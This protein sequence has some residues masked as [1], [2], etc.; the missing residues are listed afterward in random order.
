MYAYISEWVRGILNA[1]FAAV[2]LWMY[3]G[4]F[5]GE[6][7]EDRKRLLFWIPFL[8]WHFLWIWLVL[9]GVRLSFPVNTLINTTCVLTAA[10]GAY[11]G[12]L[13]IKAGF[14]IAYVGID[15]LSE[16]FVWFCLSVFYAPE[17]LEQLWWA[18][19]L[20]RGVMIGFILILR[21]FFKRKYRTVDER[22]NAYLLFVSLGSIFVVHIIFQA[23]ERQEVGI[24]LIYAISCGLVMMGVNALVYLI[25]Y[26][27]C[28]MIE[29]RQ[30]KEAFEYLVKQYSRRQKEQQENFLEERRL[31]HDFRKDLLYLRELAIHG[32]LDKITAF[33]GEHLQIIDRER[34]TVI[35]T[36]NL[37]VDALVNDQY[38]AAARAG[39]RFDTDIRI[40]GELPF[41]GSDLCMILGNLL[42]NALEA[43]GKV[44]PPGGYLS[45]SIYYQD[46]N[47]ILCVENSYA[48]AVRTDEKG[49]YLTG[50]SDPVNHGLG[51]DIV[52]KAVKK[53]NGTMDVRYDGKKFRV[54][55]VLYE[56]H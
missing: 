39:V 43:A 19:I 18:S 36:N 40:P 56:N 5:L 20:S 2:I 54:Q 28:K 25:H 37:A 33:L 35:H 32:Q 47:L 1:G 17:Q 16:V 34:E 51:L 4:M 38:Q 53:Y 49:N 11:R 44:E 29:L 52:S 31:R 9:R 8:S 3:L 14:A 23:Y 21:H 42:D 50:K 10:C 45:V 48:E 22:Y 30:E 46:G 26:D 24:G 55:I 13:R 7:R 41:A 12:R 6:K 15:A 27:T